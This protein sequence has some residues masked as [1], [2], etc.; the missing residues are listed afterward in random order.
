MAITE[1]L[2]DSVLEAAL[3]V[4]EHSADALETA[5]GVL[6]DHYEHVDVIAAANG[7]LV[8]ALSATYGLRPPDSVLEDIADTVADQVSTWMA[9][10]RVLFLTCLAAAYGDF[11][12]INQLPKNLLVVIIVVLLG[13]VLENDRSLEAAMAARSGLIG[14]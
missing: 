5:V 2:I 4:P 12:G 10:D 14:I 6:G 8:P 7:L 9:V 13:I 3:V 11:E 1:R